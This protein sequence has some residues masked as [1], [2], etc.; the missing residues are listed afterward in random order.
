[1]DN[2]AGPVIVGIATIAVSLGLA[3]LSIRRQEL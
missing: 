1:V 2:L 3:W